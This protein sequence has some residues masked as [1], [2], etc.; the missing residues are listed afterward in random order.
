MIYYVRGFTALDE[1]GNEYQIDEY[2]ELFHVDATETPQT[3]VPGL[4]ILMT[5]HGQPIERVARGTYQIVGTTI[6]LHAVTP[7]AP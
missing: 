4:K 7:D 3:K 5:E 2:T 1:Q 6:I